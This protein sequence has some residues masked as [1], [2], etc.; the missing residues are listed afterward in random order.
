[1]MKQASY[2]SMLSDSCFKYLFK[3]EEFRSFFEDI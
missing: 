1:M 3:K 2:I